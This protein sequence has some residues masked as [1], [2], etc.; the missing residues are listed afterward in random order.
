METIKPK[1]ALLEKLPARVAA[2][3]GVFPRAAQAGGVIEV[4]AS[5]PDDVTL[6]DNLRTLFQSPVVLV[7]S[8]L[9]DIEQAIQRGYGI[10]ARLLE[11]IPETANESLVLPSRANDSG[12]GQ[13][14]NDL[15]ARACEV[16]ATDI[17]IEPFQGRLLVRFRIDGL[18]QLV[19]VPAGLAR[20]Q[21]LLTSRI[22]VMAQMNIAERR[23]PQDGRIHFPY[24][25]EA[26][27]IRVSTVPVPS[28]ESINLRLLPRNRKALALQDLGIGPEMLGSLQR[29]I[30]KP[31]G[32]IL[33]TG[34]TGHGKTTTLYACLAEI[35]SSERKIITIEDPIEFLLA[36][37]NQIQ[38]HAK[39]GL[40][41]GRGLRS[42]LRQDPDVIMVGEIRD[43]ETAEIAIRAALTGHLVLS[44]LHTNDAAGAIVRLIDMG[45][46][47]H[48]VASSVSAVIGQRLARRT[49]SACEGSGVGCPAC[50][51]S[52]LRGRTGLFEFLL[53]DESFHDLIL[54]RAPASAIRQLATRK[55]MKTLSEDGQS[56]VDAGLTTMAEVSRVVEVA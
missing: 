44:T 8:T 48:L 29:L 36:G 6:L 54:K 25:E 22:K 56:K 34:P 5:R 12:I 27:D 52:G 55:G 7:P 26:F 13:F 9:Q 14:V 42:I 1:D 33:V 53:L 15:I 40:T 38:V 21:G 20:V 35:N 3:W 17:H 49:C 50:S 41:F 30:H 23:L 19:P 51:G 11:Q 43:T 10:G 16:R 39:I 31:N 28:G 24:G 18:L 32:L 47:P 2:A 4:A 45:I 37:V 46:E